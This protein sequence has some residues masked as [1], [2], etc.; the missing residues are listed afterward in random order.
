VCGIAAVVVVVVLQHRHQPPTVPQHVEA[1]MP[2][3]GQGLRGSHRVHLHRDGRCSVPPCPR[4]SRIRHCCCECC[5]CWF[6]GK[7]AQRDFYDSSYFEPE[8]DMEERLLSFP[9]YCRTHTFPP[10]RLWMMS[11]MLSSSS[12]GLVI[13]VESPDLPVPFVYS[14]RLPCYYWDRRELGLVQL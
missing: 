13:A 9:W 12:E 11:L 10:P 4:S 2:W 14:D 1:R 6:Q 3:K 8:D 7:E 5:C